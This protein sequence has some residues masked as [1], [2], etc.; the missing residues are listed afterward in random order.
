MRSPRGGTCVKGIVCGSICESL[1]LAPQVHLVAL[2]CDWPHCLLTVP[3]EARRGYRIT[4]VTGYIR[5][6][7]VIVSKFLNT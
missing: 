6:G 5:S 1:K 2:G 3:P 7:A 4:G